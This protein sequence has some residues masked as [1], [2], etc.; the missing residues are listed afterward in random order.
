MVLTINPCLAIGNL[1]DLY[2]PSFL[3]RN[4]LLD[5]AND[6]IREFV[7]APIVSS[8]GMFHWHLLLLC[9]ILLDD[10]E[11]FSCLKSLVFLKSRSYQRETLFCLVIQKIGNNSLIL[12]ALFAC[13]LGCY[14]VFRLHSIF[15]MDGFRVMR[16]EEVIKQI[17]ILVTC[18]GRSRVRLC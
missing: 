12:D 9:W 3:C 2:S 1:L 6:L 17:D 5:Q 14:L 8:S 10:L 18:T 11:F 7:F 15:S 16:M 13:P 4:A